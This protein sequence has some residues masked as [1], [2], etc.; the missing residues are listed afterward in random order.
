MV[1]HASQITWN[2][3]N[4]TG[5]ALDFSAQLYENGKLTASVVAPKAVVNTREQ[6]VIA[7]G[8]VTLKSQ[9]RKTT[10]KASWMKWYARKHRVIGDGGVRVESPD[11]NVEGAAFEADTGLKNYR[12]MDSAEGLQP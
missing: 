3:E 11:W 5:A 10:V 6:L 8:G 1:A 2:G 7:T 4:M 12:I 9:E